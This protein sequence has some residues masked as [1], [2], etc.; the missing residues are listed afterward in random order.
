MP[1]STLVEVTLERRV[2]LRFAVAWLI[3]FG[4]LGLFVL[5]AGG[6]AA[7]VGGPSVAAVGAVGAAFGAMFRR[8]VWLVLAGRDGQRSEY[9][10]GISSWLPNL[11]LGRPTMRDATLQSGWRRLAAYLAER[12]VRATFR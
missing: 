3:A 12:G 2:S 11:E 5:A 6:L 7:S 4:V 8:K 10:L 1:L 9:F